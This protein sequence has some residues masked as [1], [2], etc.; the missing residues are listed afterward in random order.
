MD[1]TRFPCRH[2]EENDVSVGLLTC[3]HV[4]EASDFSGDTVALSMAIANHRTAD[5]GLACFIVMMV[6]IHMMVV[7]VG[8]ELKVCRK[9]KTSRFFNFTHRSDSMQMQSG[10]RQLIP[11]YVMIIFFPIDETGSPYTRQMIIDY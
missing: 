9:Y 10:G 4:A 5:N 1:R 2:R 7:V 6:M 8:Q 11:L 3:P